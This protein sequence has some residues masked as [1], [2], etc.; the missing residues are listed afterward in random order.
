MLDCYSLKHEVVGQ[1]SEDNQP[2]SCDGSQ[3]KGEE[4]RI[5]LCDLT[6]GAMGEGLLMVIVL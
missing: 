6:D 5:V 3:T 1:P 4:L 2:S